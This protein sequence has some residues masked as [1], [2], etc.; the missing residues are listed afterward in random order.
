M[1]NQSYQE[2]KGNP[3]AAQ[4]PIPYSETQSNEESEP[5]K[6]PV[7]PPPPNVDYGAAPPMPPQ[8]QCYY[9]QPG[10]GYNQ[11]PDLQ[12]PQAVFIVPAQSTSEPEHLGY[13]IF[14]MLCC[15]LPLGIAALVYSVKT[16]ESNRNGNSI[17]AQKNSR[18]ALVM[19]HISL[20]LGLIVWILYITIMVI[21]IKESND[22]SEVNP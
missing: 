2:I 15:F 17:A 12:T 13:S 7:R 22:V 20:G 9:G 19:G 18:L 16:K 21:Q 3:P 10:P 1:S 11:G 6:L 8:Y 4:N 14:T 5:L